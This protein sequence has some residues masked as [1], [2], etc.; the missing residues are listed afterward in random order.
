MHKDSRNQKKKKKQKHP[1]VRFESDGIPRKEKTSV[2]RERDR[3]LCMCYGT[4]VMMLNRIELL[5]LILF[6]RAHFFSFFY[7]HPLIR[8]LPLT[9]AKKNKKPTKRKTRS[10][11][12]FIFHVCSVLSVSEIRIYVFFHR[13]KKTKRNLKLLIF[14]RLLC[15]LRKSKKERKK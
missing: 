4:C 1:G 12:F 3:E 13:A 7:S 2:Q 15:R 6:E 9:N 5:I 14:P 10:V 8:S 11:Y